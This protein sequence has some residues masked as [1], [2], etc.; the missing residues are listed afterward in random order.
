M[1]YVH[2]G[3]WKTATTTVQQLLRQGEKPLRRQSAFFVDQRS[4]SHLSDFQPKFRRAIK[5]IQGR[6]RDVTARIDDAANVFLSLSRDGSR[7]TAVHSWEGLLGHPLKSSKD[8][9]YHAEATAEWFEPIVRRADVRFV[10]TI[11]KQEDLVEAMYGQEVRKGR[12]NYGIDR[13]LW[14][15]L[16]KDL[17][18]E[19]VIT[20]FASRFGKDRIRVVPFES[21]RSGP[22]KFVQ[23]VLG[24]A[25]NASA[26]G[27]PAHSNPSFSHVAV[28]IAR[29]AVPFLEPADIAKL[30]KFL[31]DNFSNLTHRR[32]EFLTPTLRRLVQ[33]RYGDSNRSIFREHM[34]DYDPVSLGYM[35]AT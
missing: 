4:E 10:L 20:P 23:A 35:T 14:E 32:S 19:R 24:D 25:V 28:E 31:Q 15:W 33:E 16:P 3:S 6:S 8:V 2:L 9:M 13:F 26:L 34:P 17:S 5:A 29:A 30:E 12:A 22:R 21:I 27:E 18:W 7:G 11:R 1:I